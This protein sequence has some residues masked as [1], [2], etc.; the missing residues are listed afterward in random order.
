MAAKSA[1]LIDTSL[2]FDSPYVRTL[3]EVPYARRLR[4]VVW[5]YV[6]PEIVAEVIATAE[7]EKRV[8]TVEEVT[9]AANL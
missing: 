7:A 1:C 8:L 4:F 9:S 2:T 5:A 6:K 3:E